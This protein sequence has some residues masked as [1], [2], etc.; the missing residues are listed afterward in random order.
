MKINKK[1]DIWISVVIYTLIIIVAILIILGAGIPLMEGLRDKNNFV[2]SKNTLNNVN[3]DVR[4]VAEEGIGSQRIVGIDVPEGTVRIEDNKIQWELETKTKVVEPKTAIQEG[5]LQVR[6]AADVKVTETEDG[7]Y[8]IENSRVMANLSKIGNETGWQNINTVS[9][10]NNLLTKETNAYTTGNFTFKLNSDAN[11]ASGN[12][13]TTML[14]TGNDLGYATYLAHINSS[15]YE[16]DL[17][18]TLEGEADFLT[19]EVEN[20]KPK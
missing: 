16:Y 6:A 17:K 12:G 13:Y 15:S 3:K 19:V 20:I 9:L 18:L 4:N 1:G 2:K 10:I 8:L 14:Q 5:Y 11:S 7:T